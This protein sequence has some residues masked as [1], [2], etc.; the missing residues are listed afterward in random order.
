MDG[1]V[2]GDTEEQGEG[3]SEVEKWEDLKEFMF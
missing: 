1:G 2:E 3:E